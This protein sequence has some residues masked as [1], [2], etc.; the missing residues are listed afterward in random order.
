MGCGN[1][2]WIRLAQNGVQLQAVFVKKN[3]V[4]E[5]QFVVVAVMTSLYRTYAMWSVSTPNYK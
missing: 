5:G 4:L 2:D 1:V 3:C